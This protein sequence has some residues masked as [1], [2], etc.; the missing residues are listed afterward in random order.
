MTQLWMERLKSVECPDSTYGEA[1][2]PLVF[3]SASGSRITDV[4]GKKYIDLCAG[5]GVMALGHNNEIFKSVLKDQIDGHDPIYHGMGDVYPSQDKIEFMENLINILPE[6]ITKAA[7]ALTGAGANEIALKTCILHKPKGKIIVFEGSYHG[8]DL[9]VL[10]L[11]S[12]HDFKDPFQA[13]LPEDMVIELPYDCGE[14][15]LQEAFA[16]D[17]IAG[18]F[19]EPIQGRVGIRK[20]R[21]G[22]LQ[23]IRSFCD[24]HS[25][26][27][28]FDE[29]F[30]GLGRIGTV[31]SA[32]EVPADLICLGKALGGGLP[33][34]AC[35]GTEKAFNNWPQSKGEAIHTGT[36]FGHPLSCR[37]GS[38]FLRELVASNLVLRS[39]E[40]GEKV[41]SDLKERLSG[42]TGLKEVR[43]FG[44]MIAVEFEEPGRG[45]Q[46]M[47]QLR[48]EGVI[49]LASG[50]KGESF[51]M[52]PALNISENDL[53]EAL[54]K[55]VTVI[56]DQAKLS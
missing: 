7:L 6:S 19:V 40:W 30:T 18:V 50:P 1:T 8:L 44:L 52:T 48:A 12:R 41:V 23:S 22:W 38:A 49:V 25:A 17:D 33:L 11:A 37:S 5:F 10:P 31:S 14:E 15:E 3:K 54:D 46:L 42:V 55:I 20:A 34:S 24:F 47:D 29:V 53:N 16:N 39:K 43:G 56:H 2:P 36:F 35:C 4:A 27:L 32:F 28:V 26:L 51:S 45:A 13:W 21:D 9:G